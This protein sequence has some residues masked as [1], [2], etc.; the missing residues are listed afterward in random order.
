MLNITGIFNT[1][2]IVK[3][4]TDKNG[5]P[6]LMVSGFFK[7]A[8]EEDDQF[9]LIKLFGSNAEFVKRNLGSSSRRVFITGELQLVSTKSKEEISKK[10]KIEDKT[11]KISFDH[12]K[13]DTLM[14]VIVNDISFLDK[15]K[16]DVTVKEVENE[17]EVTVELSEEEEEKVA[18]TDNQVVEDNKNADEESEEDIKKEC[19][20]IADEFT[21]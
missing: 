14:T 19:D 12:V 5:K 3:E 17:G 1:N 20:K 18:A 2:K 11:Y 4:G 9:S 13:T 10:V 15:K 16:E 8:G 21:E 7:T 6:Y